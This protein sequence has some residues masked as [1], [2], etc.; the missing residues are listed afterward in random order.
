MRSYFVNGGERVW[1]SAVLQTA[2]FPLLLFPVGVFCYTRRR[3]GGFS[4][5]V[6]TSIFGKPRILAAAVVAGFLAAA[7]DF[8][9]SAGMGLLPVSTSSLIFATELGFTAAFAFVLLGQRF[10]VY[11]INAVVLLTAGAVLL[12]MNAA[13]NSGGDYPEGE[14]MRD[15]AVGFLVT[16]ASAVVAGFFL[17]FVEFAY[18]RGS[19]EGRNVIT[20]D[21]VMEFQIVTSAVATLICTVGMLVNKDF[22]A[23]SKEAKDF[24]LGET[25]YYIVLISSAILVQCF[26]LGC[27]G[28]ISC[29][30]SLLCGILIAVSLPITELLSVLFYHEEFKPEKGLALFLC[31]WGFISYFCG[32][33]EQINKKENRNNFRAGLVDD[34]EHDAAAVNYSL[35]TQDSDQRF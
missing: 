33:I 9:Y 11:S 10:T 29:S 4:D 26:Y 16:A 5:V 6:S 19:D 30:S 32:E 35:I 31:I 15:Y 18:E 2:G 28:V 34:D 21:L 27:N 8:L 7:A 12:G 1:L 17:P 14:T 25:K 23:I 20:N 3:R 24:A 13:G 22:E